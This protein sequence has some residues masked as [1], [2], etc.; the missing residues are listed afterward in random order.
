[1]RYLAFAASLAIVACNPGGP[2]EQYGFVA[3]LGRD[4]VSLERV[5]RQGNRIASDEV[6]RFPRVRRRHTEI[7]LGEDGSIRHLVMDIQTSSEPDSQRNRRV[8][9]DFAHDTV[10]L[11]K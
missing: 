8:V 3:R 10:V 7:E 1:M 11:T 4:T 6:D 2:T 5:T 9:A